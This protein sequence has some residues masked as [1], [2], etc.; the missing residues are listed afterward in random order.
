MKK[1]ILSLSILAFLSACKEKKQ[2]E[3]K[4]QNAD[5]YIEYINDKGK[6]IIKENAE[7]EVIGDG[8]DWTE[9]PLWVEQEKMLLFSDVPKN[10]VYK[11]TEKEG[12]T[13]Y[14][15]PS[16][17]TYDMKHTGEM[18][19]NGLWINDKGQLVLCQHGNRAVSIMNSTLDTPKAEYSPLVNSYNNKKLNSPN[20]IVQTKNK[21]YFFTDP[22]YGISK[23]D[24]KEQESNRVYHLNGKGE[25]KAII[26]TISH[27]NGLAFSPDEQK[28]YVTNSN[29]DKAFLYE[30]QLDKDKKILTGKVLYDFRKIWKE[31]YA[32]PDGVKV[33]KQGNIFVAA[34]GGIWVFDAEGDL[35][36]K[37][38]TAKK[39]SNNA[40]SKDE[41][42]LFITNSNK[43]LRLKMR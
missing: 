23:N 4:K 31:G 32:T 2:E 14:L 5:F 25:L 7:I 35:L 1:I 22:D 9:G 42:T 13:K 3:Q 38:H 24:K 19:S 6:E 30:Y 18:G 21:D 43:V 29:P 36:V 10:K 39:S 8:F 34:P 12:V 40:L 33:D 37:I 11:W 28:L 16:G 17:L 27:P 26:D 15:E 41:K 20:D